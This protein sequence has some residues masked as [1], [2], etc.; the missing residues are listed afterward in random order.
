MVVFPRDLVIEGDHQAFIFEEFLIRQRDAAAWRHISDRECKS[1]RMVVVGVSGWRGK[2]L[3][4]RRDKR[5]GRCIPED[6]SWQ[7]VMTLV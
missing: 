1:R 5:S 3:S 2:E 6:V 4:D 7:R